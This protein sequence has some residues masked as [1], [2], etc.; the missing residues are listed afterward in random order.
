MSPTLH[1]FFASIIPF[2][3]MDLL[4]QHNTEVIH[5]ILVKLLWHRTGVKQGLIGDCRAW[6]LIVFWSLLGI[7]FCILTCEHLTPSLHGSKWPQWEGQCFNPSH[8]CLMIPFYVRIKRAKKW[9]LSLLTAQESCPTGQVS[10][11]FTLASKPGAVRIWLRL[12]QKGS[13]QVK[14]HAAAPEQAASVSSC[15]LNPEVEF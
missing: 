7:K 10:F 11:S 5:L 14:D 4:M 6:I 12:H 8:H 15:P 13:I 3:V 1:H 9:L 2:K